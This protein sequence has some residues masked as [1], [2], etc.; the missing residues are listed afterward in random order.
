MLGLVSFQNIPKGDAWGAISSRI[1]SRFAANS[2]AST[3]KPVTFPPG[4]A[5]F[6]TSPV[7]TGSPT[8]E[9]HDRNGRGRFWRRYGGG[10]AECGDYIH[11]Q[12]GEFRCQLGKPLELSLR[13]PKFKGNV[14]PFAV[15]K[16]TQPSLH[17]LNERVRRRPWLQD[18]QAPHLP[19]WLL[20]ARRK[21]P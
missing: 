19:R 7:P 8:A 13:P 3:D 11:F 18:T 2:V 9:K 21:R 5:R 14:P 12:V 15:T 17:R 16:F 6:D 20:R 10:R 1:S 4:R